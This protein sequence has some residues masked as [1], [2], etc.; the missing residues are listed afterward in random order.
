MPASGLMDLANPIEQPTNG[1]STT[2]T[3]RKKNNCNYIVT[4]SDQW[5]LHSTNGDYIK[6]MAKTCDPY[7]GPYALGYGFHSRCFASPV[8]I[9]PQWDLLTSYVCTHL[10]EVFPHYTI[11]TSDSLASSAET[12]QA[13]GPYITKLNG[14]A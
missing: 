1:K 8:F 3:N 6:L 7:H 12:K 4:T 2:S 13:A 5:Q 9:R 14:T 10:S 11:N